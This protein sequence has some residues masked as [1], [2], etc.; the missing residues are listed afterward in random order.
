MARFIRIVVHAAGKC[1]YVLSI[2]VLIQEL[3]PFSY[4][5]GRYQEY[6]MR[7]PGVFPCLSDILILALSIRTGFLILTSIMPI[8]QI[9]GEHPSSSAIPFRF[10]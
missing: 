9:D 3:L 6:S 7:S 1:I 10:Y 2:S 4:Q 5:T 8:F